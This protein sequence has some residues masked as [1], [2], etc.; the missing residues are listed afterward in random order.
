LP[1][2]LV[3]HTHATDSLLD[4]IDLLLQVMHVD[5]PVGLRERRLVDT[6]VDYG[7]GSV[8]PVFSTE[9]IAINFG[10]CFYL[11]EALHEN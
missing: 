9:H 7:P 3:A 2:H 1:S 10:W 4:L 5:S 11:S 8:T 6:L